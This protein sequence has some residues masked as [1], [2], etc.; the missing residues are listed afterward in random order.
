M[1]FLAKL[2]R[3]IDGNKLPCVVL[4]GMTGDTSDQAVFG[5][6][7]TKIHGFIT[8]VEKHIGMVAP[9]LVNRRDTAVT[10]HRLRQG[11][12]RL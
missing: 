6:T 11:Q 2:A 8:L 3:R 7:H 12:N 9:H 10:P 4:L 5:V 1:T